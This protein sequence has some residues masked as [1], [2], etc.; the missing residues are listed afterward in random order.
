MVCSWL[1]LLTLCVISKHIDKTII[2]KATIKIVWK[3][4]Q[5][6]CRGLIKKE[7]KTKQNKTKTKTKQN[8]SKTKNKQKKQTKTK[9]KKNPKKQTKQ[10]QQQR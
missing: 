4:R 7:T 8:K 9:Q 5:H 10:Q 3:R 6:H 1:R 2:T